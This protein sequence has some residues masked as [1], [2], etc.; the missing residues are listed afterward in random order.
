MV[1][2]SDDVNLDRICEGINKYISKFEMKEYHIYGLC[3][4]DRPHVRISPTCPKSLV[5]LFQRSGYTLE[6]RDSNDRHC[7]DCDDT[8]S[9]GNC[10]CEGSCEYCR[11]DVIAI[12]LRRDIRGDTAS[13][14]RLIKTLV[15]ALEEKLILEPDSKLHLGRRVVKTAVQ[16]AS[17]ETTIAQ[18]IEPAPERRWT[19]GAALANLLEHLNPSRPRR[20]EKP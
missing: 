12:G 18:A 17:Q 11:P 9:P 19:P 13:C 14:R 2:W 16:V 7:N 3:Q 8:H 15:F 20:E 5:E 1:T 10:H 6:V 4:E